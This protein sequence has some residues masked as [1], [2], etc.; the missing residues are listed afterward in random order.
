MTYTGKTETLQELIDILTE[1]RDKQN[2]DKN[3]RVRIQG[4]YSSPIQNI[5][6]NKSKNGSEI[7]LTF[8]VNI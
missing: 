5:G 2:F 3:T 6:Y 8:H 1:L 4:N 7:F